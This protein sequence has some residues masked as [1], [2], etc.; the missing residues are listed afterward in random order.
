MLGA[1][2]AALGLTAGS[3]IPFSS[4]FMLL[5]SVAKTDDTVIT[6]YKVEKVSAGRLGHRS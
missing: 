2:Q 3:Q 5:K 4:R 1:G 6:S